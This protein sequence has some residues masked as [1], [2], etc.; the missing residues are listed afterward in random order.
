MQ[1][2]ASTSSHTLTQVNKDIGPRHTDTVRRLGPVGS[3]LLSIRL[4]SLLISPLRVG[5]PQPGKAGRGRGANWT[6]WT[7][8][9]DY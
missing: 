4:L 5:P 2:S 3:Y 9:V 7:T 1:F 8:G 6:N